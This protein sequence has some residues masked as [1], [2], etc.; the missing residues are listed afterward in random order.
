MDPLISLRLRDPR[1]VHY[2]GDVLEVEYQVDAIQPRD[3]QAI[4]ASVLWYT[5]GKGDEDLG[6]H[7]FERRV[8]SDAVDGNLC[9]LYQFQT[10]LPNSP[11]SYWGMIIRI[12]WCVR[13]RVFLRGGRE[14]SLEH[15]FQLGNLPPAPVPA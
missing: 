14:V 9:Q 13:V 7:Y 8:M 3:L 1:R 11:L 5:E 10:Q 2:P 6:V 4:E 12:R 15:P